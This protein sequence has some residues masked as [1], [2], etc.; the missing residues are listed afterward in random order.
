MR[1][2]P[3]RALLPRRSGGRPHPDRDHPARRSAR[4]LRRGCRPGRRGRGEGAGPRRPGARRRGR[5]SPRRAS[6]RRPARRSRPRSA[7]GRAAGRLPLRPAAHRGVRTGRLL[8][9]A[10]AGHGAGVRRAATALRRYRPG[11]CTRAASAGTPPR[12]PTATAPSSTRPPTRGSAARAGATTRPGRAF[13]LMSTKARGDA[14]VNWLLAPDANGNYSANARRLGV[15]QILW[16]DR[17]WNT[18]DD[19]GVVVGGEDA[20]VRDRSLRPRPHRPHLPRR[21]RS[22]LLLGRNAR[23]RAEDE[24]AAVVGQRHRSADDAVV[25]QLPLDPAPHGLLEESGGTSSWPG[26]STPTA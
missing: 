26:T 3:V 1:N 11:R 5:S 7:V 2:I 9:P 25:V 10:A 17:C 15:Q 12:N 20:Q 4:F 23:D 8:R 21:P 13:D 22:H 19:R 6:P 16:W 24:R 18:D 14:V